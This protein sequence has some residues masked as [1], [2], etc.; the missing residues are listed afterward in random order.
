MVEK[1][2]E[3][4]RVEIGLH[5]EVGRSRELDE[6]E[7]E[8][9]ELIESRICRTAG[10]LGARGKAKKRGQRTFW[11]FCLTAAPFLLRRSFLFSTSSSASSSPENVLAR[12]LLVGSSS[13]PPFVSRVGVV[14]DAMETSPDESASLASPSKTS[15]AL[16]LDAETTAE[17]ESSSLRLGAGLPTTVGLVL[18]IVGRARC[19]GGVPRLPLR[20]SDFGGRWGFAGLE[21]SLDPVAEVRSVPLLL[22][23]PYRLLPASLAVCGGEGRPLRPLA[24][25]R[26]PAGLARGGV[27]ERPTEER[28]EW[29]M[30]KAEGEAREGEARERRVEGRVRE[31]EVEEV[32]G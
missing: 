29:E 23:V 11:F 8:S 12:N 5:E 28:L 7:W 25:P 27:K 19:L 3:R 20:A 4:R 24:K 13:P 30:V 9:W 31:V 21:P 10:E 15:R 6:E 26:N 14:E 1:V 32:E 22:V 18:P 2:E 16:L 17:D